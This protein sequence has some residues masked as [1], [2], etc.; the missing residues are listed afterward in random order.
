ME[1]TNNLPAVRQLFNNK[2]KF[3]VV[4][5]EELKK[6]N[7]AYSDIQRS[8]TT[9][10]AHYELIDQLMTILTEAEQ[11]PV[12]D[13]IYITNQGGSTALRNVEEQYGNVKNILQAWLLRKVTGKIFIPRLDSPD[14]NVSVA[15]AYHDKG[16]DVAFGHDVKDCSNMSIFGSHI[17]HTYGSNQNVDYEKMM[18]TIRIWANNMDKMHEDD[19]KIIKA[20]TETSIT[21]ER[22]QEF[23]GKLL[24]LANAKNMNRPV[25]APLNVTQV[26]EVSKGLLSCDFNILEEDEKEYSLWRF[27]ND[28]TAV[29]KAGNSD[30][31]TLLTDVTEIGNMMVTEFKLLNEPVV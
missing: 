28:M 30:I 16:I 15:F 2:E 4:T 22:A 5:L 19:L 8:K 9:P 26:S 6:T 11:S 7:I 18:D 14:M 27:Y 12:L 24:I 10:V 17:F 21:K 31:T 13:H 23:L 29:L 1:E 20:M 25:V 3:E